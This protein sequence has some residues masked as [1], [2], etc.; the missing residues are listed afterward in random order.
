MSREPR[1]IV[2]YRLVPDARV[3]LRQGA[4]L[5]R[6]DY[7]RLTADGVVGAGLRPRR[8]LPPVAGV[9]RRAVV[10]GTRRPGVVARVGALPARDDVLRA[11]GSASYPR[12]CCRLL[13]Q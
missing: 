11:H 6:L 13:Y 1:T 2:Y 9:A 3:A 10:E 8:H 7:G 5:E 4:V 12:A